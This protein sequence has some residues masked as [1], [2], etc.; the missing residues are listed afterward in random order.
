M[1]YWVKSPALVCMTGFV[2]ADGTRQTKGQWLALMLI[3]SSLAV[4]DAPNSLHPNESSAEHES[5]AVGAS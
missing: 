4:P 2:F 1:A 5:V 3:S